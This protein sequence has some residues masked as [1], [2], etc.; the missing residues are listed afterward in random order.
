MGSPWFS[1]I[2][3]DLPRFFNAA[4]FSVSS[5]VCGIVV[6]FLLR[7]NFHFRCFVWKL[8]CFGVF[9][10]FS[11]LHWQVPF[12]THK[13]YL[14]PPQLPPFQLGTG[15]SNLVNRV[16]LLV[17]SIDFTCHLTGAVANFISFGNFCTLI[18]ILPARASQVPKPSKPNVSHHRFYATYLPSAIFL[19]D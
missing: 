12:E 3:C 18:V 6:K 19:L 4:I 11:R 15:Q 16:S 8:P 9:V 17:E 5:P 14:S 13:I 7:Y 1:F 2:L 10:N